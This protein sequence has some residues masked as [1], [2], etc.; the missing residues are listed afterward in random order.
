MGSREVNKL[1]EEWVSDLLGEEHLS[2][3]VNS[4]VGVIRYLTDKIKHIEKVI[5]SKLKLRK[6]FEG[7]LTV[8]GIG[9]ILGFI[10]MLEV[11]D[12]GRFKEVGNYS[13]YCRCVRSI[14]ISNEKKKEEGNRKNGNKYLSWAYVEAANF[15]V[16]S[17]ARSGCL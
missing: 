5:K 2:L 14:R 1:D 16:R 8:P 17:Y 13:S 15:A 9:N 12:I 3:S 10:I 4:S 11:G 7:L 6:E